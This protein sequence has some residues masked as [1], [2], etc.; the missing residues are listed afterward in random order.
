[1]GTQ[2]PTDANAYDAVS[3]DMDEYK[4]DGRAA[5]ES[6]HFGGMPRWQLIRFIVSPICGLTK[7]SGYFGI[8]NMSFWYVLRYYDFTRV[9]K[10][11]DHIHS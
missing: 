1:M 9:R 6:T 5:G 7:R 4:V 11:R 10:W 3:N 8:L 2:G